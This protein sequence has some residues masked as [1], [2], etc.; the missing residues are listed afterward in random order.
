MQCSSYFRVLQIA[1]LTLLCSTVAHA[2]GTKIHKW[3]DEKGVT[4]YGDKMPAKDIYRENS[5]LNNQGVTI[6]RNQVTN[7]NNNEM[8]ADLLEQKRRDR[9]LRASYTNAEEIDLARNRSLEMDQASISALEQRKASAVKRLENV[10]KSI[11]GFAQKEK[12]I[13]DDLNKEAQDIKAEIARIDD[14]ISHRKSSM[15]ATNKRF[16]EDKQRYMEIKAE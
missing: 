10:Q 14:Q 11:D 3:V 8:D 5:V 9:A 15:E 6:K 1:L 13:P 4:H 2:G 12:P 16:N 7:I